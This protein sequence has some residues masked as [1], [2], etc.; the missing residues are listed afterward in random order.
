MEPLFEVLVKIGEETYPL[1]QCEWVWFRKCGCPF[2]CCHA[3]TA[4]E[5]AAWKDM[6]YYAKERNRY[7]K[8][9]VTAELMPFARAKE[10]F[11]PKMGSGYICPH[12]KE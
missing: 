9:G 4:D 1:E 5:E 10:D 8:K 6:F 2:A 7:R 12:G 11:F 3:E